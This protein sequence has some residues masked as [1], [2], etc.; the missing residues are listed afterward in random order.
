MKIQ[1]IDALNFN[2]KTFVQSMRETGFAI[3]KNYPLDKDLL[4]DVYTKWAAFF[5]QSA[6]EKSNFVSSKDHSGYFP[7][8]SENAKDSSIKDLKEF[9]HVYS[10][11]ELPPSLY[12]HFGR[13]ASI[14]P[15]H[16]L[17][18]SLNVLGHQLLT[19]LW[20]FS[21]KECRP[22]MPYHEMIED[23]P[24]TLFRALH[25]P[26]IDQ[27]DSKEGAVRA[28]AHEDINLITLLPA[29]TYPGLQ[30]KDLQ[31]NWHIIECDPG[32]IVVNVGDMIQEA[33]S[34]F[35]KST[36]HR[37]V[38]PVG[39]GATVSRYSL[40]LFIHPTPETRLSERYTAAEYLDER[41]KALG[42]K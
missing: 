27:S 15:T 11:T 18:K 23:S 1:T 41:L 10:Y 30:V 37:V 13:G 26:P 32:M 36:T 16:E 12:E 35:Y 38:N 31:G 8:K 33:S 24:S 5:K 17:M 20:V 34:G 2:S 21:P 14:S 3:I 28:A 39:L 7:F 42:L 25:Y 40:P 29:A 9:Y 22:M 19:M 4:D 6:A